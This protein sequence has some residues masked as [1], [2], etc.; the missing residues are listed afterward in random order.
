MY[1]FDDDYS[2][3]K[4][5]LQTTLDAKLKDEEEKVKMTVQVRRVG[6]QLHSEAGST[7]TVCLCNNQHKQNFIHKMQRNKSLLFCSCEIV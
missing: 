3:E 1:V 4:L 6:P 7:A 2:A 5:A